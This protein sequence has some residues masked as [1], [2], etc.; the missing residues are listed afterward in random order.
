M[1][2]IFWEIFILSVIVLPI[3]FALGIGLI[4]LINFFDRKSGG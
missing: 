3:S 1:M 2:E 4:G